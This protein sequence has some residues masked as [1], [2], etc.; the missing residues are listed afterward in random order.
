VVW[1]DL[2][3]AIIA[4]GAVVAGV[5]AMRRGSPD[6]RRQQWIEQELAAQEAEAPGG[7]FSDEEYLL[8]LEALER[9]WDDGLAD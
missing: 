5:V 7:R 8:R 6:R 3:W 9:R 1:G 4:L 2:A